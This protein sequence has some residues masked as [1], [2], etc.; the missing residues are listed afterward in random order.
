MRSTGAHRI[1]EEKGEITGHFVL[2]EMDP[3]LAAP[4]VLRYTPADG[5]TLRLID[6]P[7]GWPTSLGHRGDLVVHGTTSEGGHPLTLLDARVSSI[8]LGNRV[9]ALRATTLALGAHFDRETTWSCAT[10]TTAHLHEWLGDSGLRQDTTPPHTK[11]YG[12][13]A[14]LG[15]ADRFRRDRVRPVRS[16]DR[17]PQERSCE[18][19]LE[20]GK[21]RRDRRARCK[22]GS[23]AHAPVSDASAPAV[24]RR[25]DRDA[26]IIKLDD[27]RGRWFPFVRQ[28]LGLAAIFARP[29]ASGDP[30]AASCSAPSRSKTC[31]RS[32]GAGSRCG[33]K[34]RGR[35]RRFVDAITEGN[36]YSRARLLASVVA[37]EG[38]WRTRKPPTAGNKP[39]LLDKLIALRGHSGVVEQQIGATDDNLKLLVAARNLY[40][41]LDQHHVSL[42]DE[43]IDD[44]LL[45]NCRRA[46][47][48]M[49]ACLLRDLGLTPNAISEMFAE[50][51][52]AWP[53]A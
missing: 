21:G 33:V 32:T 47:A 1:L 42:S 37:L 31:P 26:R 16:E 43:E 39:K 35:S 11:D 50:H 5:T 14:S 12:A 49:Q 38:Y 53:L 3:E 44:E 19:A 23:R 20:D 17:E 30:M 25:S 46:T 41:H 27:I 13:L 22:L 29:H 4:G 36:T 10:Y 51:H 52:A 9:T 18:P 48:L 6:A 45:P 2:R 24:H 8:A 15:I 40:A 28:V 34:Q 7:T